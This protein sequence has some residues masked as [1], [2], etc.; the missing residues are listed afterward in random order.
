MRESDWLSPPFLSGKLEPLNWSIDPNSINRLENTPGILIRWFEARDIDYSEN[1][2]AGYLHRAQ[3]TLRAFSRLAEKGVSVPLL[4]AVVAARKNKWG[5]D[6]LGICTAV[7]EIEGTS[8]EHMK[9]LPDA[10]S[11]AELDQL[12]ALLIQD[13]YQAFQSGQPAFWDFHVSQF[14]YGHPVGTNEPKHWWVLDVGHEGVSER[15]SKS[16]LEE[17]LNLVSRMVD[18]LHISLPETKEQIRAI[19]KKLGQ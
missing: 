4:G 2:S 5:G 19:R 9:A 6:T 11:Q 14:K 17:K 18:N 7:K 1:P 13:M 16:D 8:L 15:L 12:L 10:E 3:I